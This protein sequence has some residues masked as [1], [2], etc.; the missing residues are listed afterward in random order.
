MTMTI[1]RLNKIHVLLSKGYTYREIGKK[2]KLPHT[3]VFHNAKKYPVE[4]EQ[5]DV[6]SVLDNS[7]FQKTLQ[8]RLRELRYLNAENILAEIKS[9]LRTFGC[10]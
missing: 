6:L 2:L 3:T 5:V 7:D 1:K 10:H 9:L 8:W 4:D